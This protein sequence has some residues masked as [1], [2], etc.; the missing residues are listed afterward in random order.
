MT[1]E[2]ELKHKDRILFGS[3]H[4]YV[5]MNPK[6]QETAPGTPEYLT[7]DFAQNEIAKAKGYATGTDGMSKDQQRAQEQVLEL[8]PLLSEATA[9]R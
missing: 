2:I 6:K 8:L 5:F 1:N 4:M 9:I 3:N 7:W